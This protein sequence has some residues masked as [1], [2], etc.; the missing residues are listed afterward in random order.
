MAISTQGDVTP[1]TSDYGQTS[2]GT[3]STPDQSAAPAGAPPAGATPAGMVEQVQPPPRPEYLS[4]APTAPPKPRGDIYGRAQG[5]HVTTFGHIFDILA[6]PSY[7]QQYNPVSGQ[8]ENVAVKRSRTQLA[9]SIL[10]GALTGLFAGSQQRGPGA[11]GKAIGAGAQAV[12]GQ[13]EQQRQEGIKQAQQAYQNQQE[14]KVRAAQIAH[15]NMETY[16]NYNQ[17]MHLNTETQEKLMDL[18]REYLSNIDEFDVMH[19][20]NYQSI[21]DGIRNNTIDPKKDMAVLEGVDA[22]GHGIMAIVKN[23]DAPYKLSADQTTMLAKYDPQRWGAMAGKEVTTTR[24]VAREALGKAEGIELVRGRIE[25][26]NEM[27]GAGKKKPTSQSSDNI[28]NLYPTNDALADTIAA[29]EGTKPT[30]RSVRNNN[31]GNLVFAHQP[32]A[33]PEANPPA[34]QAPLAAFKTPEEGRQALLNQL[35]KWRKEQPSLTVD[36]FIK[37]KKESGFAG[38]AAPEAAGNTQDSANAYVKNLTSSGIHTT[39]PGDEIQPFQLREDLL[40]GPNGSKYSEALMA[41]KRYQAHHVFGPDTGAELESMGADKRD[42]RTGVMM[43]NPD[44]KYVPMLKELF[45]GETRLQ[46]LHNQIVQQTEFAKEKGRAEAQAAVLDSPNKAYGILSRPDSTP[47]QIHSA[48]VYL[49]EHKKETVDQAQATAQAEGKDYAAMVKTGVN[50]ITK[51]RLTLDNAPDAQ[52]VD[53]VTGIPVPTDMLATKRPTLVETQRAGY[54]TSAID[55]SETLM[56]LI[57]NKKAD[58]GPFKGTIADA[59]AKYGFGD[60]FNQEVQ[61]YIRYLQSAATAAHTGRFSVPIL[62]KMARQVD[63]NMNYDQFLGALKSTK[64][65]MSLYAE[66]GWKPTVAEYKAAIAAQGTT[67]PTRVGEL[68]TGMVPGTPGYRGTART[69]A[70]AGPT[71]G[72]GGPAPIRKRNPATN[73]TIEWDANN[74]QWVD[75]ATRQPIGAPTTPAPPPPR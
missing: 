75:V 30:D 22:S 42:P 17:A 35:D 52:L 59:A 26:Q 34:G 28:W 49:D 62:D 27:M 57:H 68:Q 25:E 51:E 18:G 11:R 7:K 29:R 65:V 48:N 46:A 19:G 37:G 39:A 32:G 15:I 24:R 47:E 38:Y 12:M 6:G 3:A 67:A 54:A 21:Q 23:G 33:T 5:E 4:A 8:Y 50:P 66:S 1:T 60:E 40:I 9:D 36:E 55:S 61:N 14:E 13:G 16:L 73:Q 45:G 70:A 64:D 72:A 63:V 41:L 69:V 10:A 2:G 56:K 44:A 31:P 53:P 58:I 43:P 20:M 74:K 71:G